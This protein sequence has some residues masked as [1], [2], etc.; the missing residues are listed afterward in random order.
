MITFLQSVPNGLTSPVVCNA[1]SLFRSPAFMEEDLPFGPLPNQSR[2]EFNKELEDYGKAAQIFK[3]VSGSMASR[4]TSAAVLDV[5]PQAQEGLHT[6]SA[7]SKE[8][9]SVE[10]E[11][12]EKKEESSKEH[13]ARVGMY[14]P[15]T[16]EIKIWIPAKL[17][18]KRFGV[19]DPN[20]EPL[21]DTVSQNMPSTSAA[22][23]KPEEELSTATGTT[24]IEHNEDGSTTKQIKRPALAN[25]GLGDDETQGQD[26]LT[27]ERPTI[28]IFKA[29]FASDDEDSDNDNKDEHDENDAMTEQS[30][31]ISGDNSTTITTLPEDLSNKDPHSETIGAIKNNQEVDISTFKPTFVPRADREKRKDSTKDRSDSKKEKKKKYGK[32]VLVSFDVEEDGGDTKTTGKEKDASKR[33]KKKKEQ[34]VADDEGMW[35]EKAPPEGLSELITEPAA[36]VGVEVND[37]IPKDIGPPR[38]RKRAI[39]FL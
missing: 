8:H 31:P 4:F 33:K 17:L 39:D 19:K 35:V 34:P 32:T 28:D 16:R 14:G 20:P 23:W 2:I 21:D 36:L 12:E 38:G 9:S 13:A 6:P 30:N 22:N 1:P 18:C 27:Y 29:I 5:K 37:V 26:V 3:P 10:T 7:N 11:K 24:P 25:I 15:L